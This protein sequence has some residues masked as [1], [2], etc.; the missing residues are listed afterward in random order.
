MPGRVRW[1]ILAAVV[2]LGA[3]AVVL[4]AFPHHG[5]ERG[6]VALLL[7]AGLLVG[8]VAG[9]V[10][11]ARPAVSSWVRG[12]RARTGPERL[13]DI[14]FSIV[15]IA[16]WAVAAALLGIWSGLLTGLV[17]GAALAVAARSAFT[18]TAR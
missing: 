10:L 11:A 5:R 18:T 15:L 2:V 14:A 17:V 1:L 16:A 7:V 6:T 12:G 4:T 8:A 3:I 9:L 13:N